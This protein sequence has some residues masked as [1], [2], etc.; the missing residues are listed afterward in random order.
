MLDRIADGAF[1]KALTD[2]ELY[3]KFS[4]I[5]VED[6]HLADPELLSSFNFALA[7]RSAAPRIEAHYQYYHTAAEPSLKAEQD[8]SCPVW[9]SFNGKQYC[10]PTLEGAHGDIDTDLYVA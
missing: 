8:S 6:G 5:L 3:E 7:A 10:S 4:E 9:V 1:D 2:K